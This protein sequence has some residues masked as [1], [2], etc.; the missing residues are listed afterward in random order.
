MTTD[1]LIAHLVLV[2]VI[3]P[4]AAA[5]I[6]VLL[7][8]RRPR[9]MA[10][11]A[12]LAVASG[13][14]AIAVVMARVAATGAPVVVHV[15]GWR[16]PFGIN[17][18]ADYLG[19]VMTLM[20]QSVMLGG[21]L[22]A[23]K[24]KDRCV[25]Y[26]VF[27]PM[28][29]TLAGGLAGG[30]LTGDLFNFFVFAELVMI[31]GTVLT[32]CSDNRRGI[33]AAYKYFYISL[34]AATG[35]LVACGCLY[36]SYGTLNIADLSRSIAARP[37]A[38]LAGVALALLLVSFSIKSAAVPFHFWQP[39]FH[40]TA[41]TAV[42]AMLSSVVVKL[43]VYGLIRL[44]TALFPHHESIGTLLVL[45]GVLGV[46]VGGLGAAGTHDLK[47]MLAYSTL[48]QIG[49]ILVAIGWGSPAALAAAIVFTF[50]H[51]FVKSSMLMLAGL[52]ASRTSVKSASFSAIT[53]IG[54]TLP[55]AGVLFLLGG[56]ALMGLPPTNGF[57]S[58][59]G[60]L[61]AGVGAGDWPVLAALGLGSVV[62]M[63]YVSRA[64]QRVWWEERPDDAPTI[65]PTRDSI[66][67]PALLISATLAL[68]V[69]PE[70][71]LRFAAHAADFISEPSNYVNASLGEAP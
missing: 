29:L 15:G 2:P 54:K 60:V 45:M 32:A 56:M 40:T 63:V 57:I 39:D 34:I 69:A 23:S 61:K 27:F 19:A 1:R 47:R 55:A 48:A 49:F 4:L 12:F 33:E 24:C 46:A 16:A 66:L 41:P 36:A 17:L 3:A 10:R 28:M 67:A 59:L 71:L 8:S 58:K 20:A 31:S 30:M 14:A 50:N 65:S 21:V 9:A 5:A 11:L 43:G 62:T 25:T 44:T 7:L 38:P 6:G 68:G 13:V 35:L 70:P 42:S 64:F 37:D 51:A 26:A 22:Y 53:G 52:V 18:V